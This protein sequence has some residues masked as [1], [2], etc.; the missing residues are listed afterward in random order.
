LAEATLADASALREQL[1]PEHGEH[2]DPRTLKDLAGAVE[3][4]LRAHQH[5]ASASNLLDADAQVSMLSRLQDD[6]KAAVAA[7]REET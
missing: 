1:W 6:L 5:L 2:L 3:R 4:L 7:R